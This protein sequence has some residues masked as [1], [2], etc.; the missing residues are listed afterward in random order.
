MKKLTRVLTATWI[1]CASFCALASDGSD[2][3]NRRHEADSNEQ[4]HNEKQGPRQDGA[5]K[6]HDSST[7][8]AEVP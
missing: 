5:A 3:L 2:A 6:R 4:Q 7:Q 8:H 1:V